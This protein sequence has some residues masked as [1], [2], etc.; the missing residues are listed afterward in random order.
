MEYAKGDDR[1]WST[2]QNIVSMIVGVIAII[3]FVASILAGT[4]SYIAGSAA[5]ELEKKIKERD[6]LIKEEF[7]EVQKT[8]K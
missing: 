3:R 4:Y 7:L 6:H 2:G 1:N 5:R 8:I